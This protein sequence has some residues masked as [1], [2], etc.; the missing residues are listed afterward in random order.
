MK[1]LILFVLIPLIA[2]GGALRPSVA[3]Q[4][5]PIWDDRYGP[6][7][8]DGEITASVVAANGDIYIS[9]KFTKAGGVPVNG[10]A[11]WDGRRWHALGEGLSGAV[12]A[13][14]AMLM[15]G[16]TLIVVGAFD[17]AGAVTANEIAAWDGAAWQTVGTGAGP[18]EGDFDGD[19][20]AVALFNGKLIV[21]G[22]FDKIDN[23]A[24]NNVAMWDGTKWSP[25][26]GGVGGLDFEDKYSSQG[27][28]RAL[29]V[30]GG[31]LYAGGEFAMA[32][33]ADMRVNSIARWD[34]TNWSAVG[35]GITA[36]DD[37]NTDQ[38]GRV[39]ALAIKDGVL[40]AGGRFT[41]AGSA[42]VKHVAV[43]RNNAWSGLG[44]GLVESL[45][46]SDPPVYA[47]AISGADVYFGGTFSS[48]G[49]QPIKLL[50]RWNGTS[51]S[52]VGGIEDT[53]AD[54]VNTLAL[55]PGGSLIVAGQM[56]LAGDRRVDHIARWTGS[57]WQALGGGLMKAGAGDV[58]GRLLKIA[59]DDAGRIYVGGMMAYAGG[60]PVSQLAMWDA[61]A[62]HNIG[63]ADGTVNAI[64]V[65]GDK[66]YFGGEFSSIG[67][68]PANR[69]AVWNRGTR[70]WSALAAGIDGTVHA[71]V[72][73]TGV[74]YVGGNFTN[75][76]GV[77]ARDVAYWDGTQWHAFGSKA[78]IFQIG[79]NAN[80][81]TTEV[82][83]LAVRGNSVFIGG[84]FTTLHLGGNLADRNNYAIVNN[85]VEWDRASDTWFG[86][87]AAP[88]IG[89][90]QDGS[91]GFTVEVRA[92]AATGDMLYAGG[93]FNRAG[94]A[95]ASNMSAW[96]LTSEQWQPINAVLG[97]AVGNTEL[98][99]MAAHGGKLFIVG[100]FTSVGNVSA[101][102][103]AQYDGATGE[104]SA[105]G[106]GLRWYD[107][108]YAIAYSV[109]ANQNGVYVGGDF[110]KAGGVPSSGF[111]HWRT[112]LVDDTPNPSL[113][114]KLY[115]PAVARGM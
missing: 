49:G 91:S 90:T 58:P 103:V 9:G 6:P 108:L 36:K 105:L 50:G 75:A 109:F 88:N 30:E 101:R 18:S 65:D 94:G 61:G 95:S 92:L 4:T 24:A 27:R 74:L 102:Y 5:P 78:S 62:W 34:G 12:P 80:E 14:S 8:V 76:G 82:Y 19:I 26:G 39:Q 41:T 40:Y 77:P 56:R 72:V 98:R 32:G 81:L 83:A 51:W 110:D 20:D 104:W 2:I 11:R 73:D 89:V 17:Q 106:E 13:P 55:A 57:E 15:N 44:A 93:R 115:I 64:A 97:S 7:G 96:N 43:W 37:N 71:L 28:V 35:A 99:G 54:L 67:G 3:Q 23:V 16:G 70:Q 85:V 22:D 113:T 46:Y 1:G 21:G 68:V 10:V 60:I 47:I 59:G 48:A 112:T 84:M 38:P 69:V 42:A 25:L 53:D 86:L 100:K 111:A 29:V 31:V 33:G 45:F 63:T 66:V 52:G 79:S 107:D 114:K 87:G